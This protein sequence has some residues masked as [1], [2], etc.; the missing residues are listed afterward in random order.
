MSQPDIQW[1]NEQLAPSFEVLR[2]LGEGKVSHV[3]LAREPGLDRLVAIKVLRKEVADDE[4]AAKRFDREARSVA[5]IHHRA[6]ASVYRVGDM[7][8]LPYLVMEYIDGRTVADT[9]VGGSR[10]EEEET[11]KALAD[12]AAALA[13]AHEQRI[14]HRDVRPGNV[15][16]E[17]RTGRFVLTDFGIAGVLESGAAVSRL[18]AI[19]EVLG[20][21]RYLSPEQLRGEPLTESADVYSLAVLGYEML[22]GEGPH[23]AGSLTQMT[24][25]HLKDPPRPLEEL[26]RGTGPRPRRSSS[27]ESSRAPQRPNR[28]RR[29]GAF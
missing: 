19:G 17:S 7:D 28:R 10:F 12:V 14:L 21:P 25:A 5:R 9:L 13:A 23:A 26:R 4:T 1:M 8:G 22:T 16:R 29:W 24:A 6:V 18:T 2:L 27:R 15:I 20:D 3:F 11:V